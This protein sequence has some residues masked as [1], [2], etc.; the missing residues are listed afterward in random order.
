M[1]NHLQDCREAMELF[2][3]ASDILKYDLYKVCTEG[4]IELLNT[5]QICQLATLVTSCGALIK[6]REKNPQVGQR[7][8]VVYCMCSSIL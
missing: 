8:G 2:T 4:P 6:L 7:L 3:I 5:T 1:G